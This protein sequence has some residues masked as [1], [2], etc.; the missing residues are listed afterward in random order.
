MKKKLIVI[1][2]VVGLMVATVVGATPNGKPFNEIWDAINDIWAAIAELNDASDLGL[3]VTERKAT[4][5]CPGESSCTQV[6]TC[7]EG[8]TLTGGGFMVND[9]GT[10]VLDI[11][12][13]SPDTI[14]ENTW[15]VTAFN[16]EVPAVDTVMQFSIYAMCATLSD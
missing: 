8:E 12:S 3:V 7:A 10:G 1:I 13:S 14:M 4:F 11:W 2:T 9:P 6:V 5:D 16:P 15:R